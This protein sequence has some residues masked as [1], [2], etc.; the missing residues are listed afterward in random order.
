MRNEDVIVDEVRRVRAELIQRY[1]GLE[2]W[3]DHLQSMDRARIG[4]AKPRAAKKPA[5]LAE[6]SRTRAGVVPARAATRR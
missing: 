4:K 3:I 2:G 1:G 5:S 6:K